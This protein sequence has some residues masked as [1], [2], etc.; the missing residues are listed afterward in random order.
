MDLDGEVESASD[1]DVESGVL[2]NPL[3]GMEL[4]EDGLYQLTDC[5]EQEDESEGM[6]GVVRDRLERQVERML[7]PGVMRRM[8]KAQFLRAHE[9]TGYETYRHAADDPSVHEA[10]DATYEMLMD[11][12]VLS[13]ALGKIDSKTLERSLVI[14]A[15]IGPV[16][17][18][19]W[20][21][22]RSRKERDKVRKDKGTE[23]SQMDKGTEDE[24]AR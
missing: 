3:E 16:V 7:D 19:A 5:L 15:G 13:S 12:P 6:P 8:V 21:E 9:R 17:Y 14:A 24:E 23:G 11:S 18:M 2:S 1:I 10:V 4:G 20:Q 22:G